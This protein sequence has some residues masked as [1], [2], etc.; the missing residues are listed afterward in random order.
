MTRYSRLLVGL[1]IFLAAVPFQAVAYPTYLNAFRT[2]Y[3]SS[4]LDSCSLCHPG[5]DTGNWNAFGFDY[6]AAAGTPDQRFQS[7][8]PLDSDDDTFNNLTEINA[9][10]DP[11][12]GSDH[13][14][15]ATPTPTNTPTA[16]PTPTRTATALPT[17]TR[18]PTAIPT[19]ATT[20]TPVQSSAQSWRDY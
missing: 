7:V 8:E 9:N 17:P 20:A 14:A 2:K 12:D 16:V 18:T 1:G 11:S 4:T 19:I 10:T 5:G 3:P 13:P 15:A 6:M